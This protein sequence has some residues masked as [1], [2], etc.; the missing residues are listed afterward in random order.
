MTIFQ[1]SAGNLVPYRVLLTTNNQNIVSAAQ[2]T[3]SIAKI[4]VDNVN[5]S[6]RTFDLEI[7]DG[8]TQ[9]YL[10]QAHS[11]AGKGGDASYFELR[12]EILPTGSILRALASAD[13]SVWI[14]VLASLPNKPTG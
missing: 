10:C 5:A 1:S 7:Y 6:A 4:W 9:Q 8:T 13:T 3:R 11:L 2:G 12:D 14:H